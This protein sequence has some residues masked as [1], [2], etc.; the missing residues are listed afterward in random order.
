MT[1]ATAA[2]RSQHKPTIPA[3]AILYAS[4]EP[5]SSHIKIIEVYK[6]PNGLAHI[7]KQFPNGKWVSWDCVDRTPAWFITHNRLHCG[8]TISHADWEQIG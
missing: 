6:L 5:N 2:N 1:N 8:W 3:G 7:I 4:A